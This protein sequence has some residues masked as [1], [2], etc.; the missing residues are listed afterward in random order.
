[1]RL[2]EPELGVGRSVGELLEPEEDDETED[3]RL[4]GPGMM[5]I[6]AERFG[7]L[8]STISFWDDILW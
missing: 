2:F 1:M 7:G 5:L 6:G 3:E 4:R 8:L